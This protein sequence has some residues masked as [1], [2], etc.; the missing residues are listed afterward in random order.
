MSSRVILRYATSLL[1]EGTRYSISADICVRSPTIED[2]G[3]VECL[4]QT[5]LKCFCVMQ[6]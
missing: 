4:I 2:L 3:L 1:G 5:K 6:N